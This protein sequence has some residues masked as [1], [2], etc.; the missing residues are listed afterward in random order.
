[1]IVTTMLIFDAMSQI[2]I[3]RN[4]LSAKQ[5]A[6]LVR[7][8]HKSGVEGVDDMKKIGKRCPRNAQRDIMRKIKKDITWPEPYMAQIPVKD[9]KN[10]KRSLA[11]FPFILVSQVLCHIMLAMGGGFKDILDFPVGSGLAN[12]KAKWEREHRVPDN[13]PLAPIGIHGDGVPIQQRS[14]IYVISWNICSCGSSER[15]LVTCISKE[16]ICDCGCGGRCSLDAMLEIFNWDLMGLYTGMKPSKR[17]DGSNWLPSDSSRKKSGPMN[18]RAGLFQCRGDWPWL[19]WLFGF[20]GWNSKD[21]VCWKCRANRSSIP[22]WDPKPSAKWRK[23]RVSV[24]EFIRLVREN[25]CDMSPLFS[26]PGF[27]LECI[28]IDAL[29][30]MDLGFS[31]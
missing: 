8:A 15:N 30:A 22:Y 9:R 11:W 6:G 31:Q 1:M 3:F 27:T 14:S 7:S 5:T 16:D 10:G 4:N 17:H 26:L 24:A 25:G 2:C 23:N 28:C 19:K 13:A 29:H 20:K 21:H 12:R 18:V